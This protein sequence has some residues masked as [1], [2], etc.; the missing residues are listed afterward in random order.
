MGIQANGRMVFANSEKDNGL[1]PS[2][3]HLF[4]SVTQAYRRSVVG[5]LLTGMGADGAAELKLMKDQ[6]AITIAQDKASSLVHGM[7]GVAIQLG[8]AAYVLS[9]PEIVVMLEKLVKKR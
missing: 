4:R 3:A 8:G 5:V 6:G 9:P 7:P 1:R 2:V